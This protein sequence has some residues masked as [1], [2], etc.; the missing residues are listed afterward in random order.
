MYA[1]K[2]VLLMLGGITFFLLGLKFMSE[3]MEKLAGKKMQK[4]LRTFTK[5]RCAGVMTGAV[6]T[7]LLQSSIATNVI[8]VG[9]VSS[10]ILSFY[11][12]SAVIMGTNIGTTITAQLVSLSGNDAFDITALGSLIAFI[13]FI[14]SFLK[15]E[16]MQYI[17]GVMA[18]F[19]MLFFGL[20]VVSDSVAFF[21]NFESFRKIFLVE[22]DLLLLLNGIVITAIIQSSSAVTSVMIILASNGLLSFESSMF[23][24]LG[25]NIGTCFSVIIAASNKPAEARRVA[26]FNIAFNIVGALVLFLPLTLFKGKISSWFMSFSGSIEREIA[27]FHTLFNMLVTIMLL[28][29]LKPFTRLICAIIKDKPPKEAKNGIG[30]T[31]NVYKYD[32][33]V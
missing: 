32:N 23:L 6:S 18:G 9:F 27:N 4:V 8:T 16:K 26:F 28:P 29:V 14:L 10:G 20:D 24:I 3:N 15:N 1:F 11:S 22:S 30:N 2:Y 12:A 21:K 19:G 33:I 25:A 13:G 31:V 5:N 7:A 17:G